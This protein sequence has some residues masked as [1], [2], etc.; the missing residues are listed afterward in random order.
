MAR[1]AGGDIDSGEPGARPPR[2]SASVV[3]SASRV[4]VS[5]AD[6]WRT[7]IGEAGTLVPQI[8]RLGCAGMV[9][10][11]I[12]ALTSVGLY[13]MVAGGVPWAGTGARTTAGGAQVLV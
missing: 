6:R 13:A 4:Q 11:L 2:G 9:L 7:T 8:F 5:F 3:R 1:G 10:I 12:A